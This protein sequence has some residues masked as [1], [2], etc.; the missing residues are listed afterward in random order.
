MLDLA[1]EA[2]G[3]GVPVVLL[4]YLNT[5]LAF[6]PERFFADCGRKGVAGVVVPDVPVEEAGDL[7]RT[8]GER[9]GGRDPARRPHQHRRPAGPH[10]GARPPA[11]STASR[12]PA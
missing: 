5:I 2:A 7:Q 6:G 4:S 8:A 1:E 10:R 11:S 9:R 3:E 12:P